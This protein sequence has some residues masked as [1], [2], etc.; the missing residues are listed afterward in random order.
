ML[1]LVGIPCNRRFK[2]R[3]GSNKIADRNLNDI[4][5]INGKNFRQKVGAEV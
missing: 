5:A 1:H 3:F 2:L 4:A